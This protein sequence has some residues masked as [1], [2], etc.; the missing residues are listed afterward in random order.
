MTMTIPSPSNVAVLDGMIEAV[1]TLENAIDGRVLL[2]GDADY[3]EARLIRLITEDSFP[4]IIIQVASAADVATAVRFARQRDMVFSV[5]SG[6]HSFSGHSTNNGGVVIDLRNLNAVVVDPETRTARAQ[7][8]ATSAVLGAAAAEHG[9]AIST[10]DTSSVALGGLTLGGGIGWM[11]REQGLTIDN[12]LSVEMVTAEGEI[13]RASKVEHAG[14]FWALRGG[15]G[16]FGIVTE[17]ELQ[18]HRVDTVLAG[19]VALPPTADVIKRYAEWAS[20]AP[21]QLTTITFLMQ[22]PPAPFVPAEAVGKLA[23]IVLIC[24]TGPIADGEALVQELRNIAQPVFE[25]VAPMPYPA[26]YAFSEQGVHRTRE[27]A[28]SM[29]MNEL[30]DDF[31]EAVVDAMSRAT[32]IYAVQLRTLGGQMARIPAGESAFAHRDRKYLFT[33]IGQWPEGDD[34][35]DAKQWVYGLYNQVNCYAKGAYVNFLQSE[36][37]RVREA[38]PA[39]TYERLVEVKRRYDPDNVFSRNTN[40]K[41]RD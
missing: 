16:N 17:F 13:I 23:F 27:V 10:G 8:G 19:L 32:P 22:A 12:L 29:F 9:L 24:Y 38:Y 11:A 3:D 36:P 5:R 14:L 2:P 26:I 37:E 35:T 28:R 41:P 33:L 6:G 7:P 25:L 4:G 1:R 15:G 40:V 39:G 30:P 21:D 18:L 34:G 20:A 31:L